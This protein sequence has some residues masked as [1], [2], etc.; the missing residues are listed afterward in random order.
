MRGEVFETVGRP[1]VQPLLGVLRL[2]RTAR[3]RGAQ[4]SDGRF[5]ACWISLVG[6]MVNPYVPAVGNLNLL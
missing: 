3:W 2:R 1:T 5:V 4:A 6:H